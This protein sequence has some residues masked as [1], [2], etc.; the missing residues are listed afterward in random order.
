MLRF[1]QNQEVTPPRDAATAV[2]VRETDAGLEVYCIKRSERSAFMGGAVVFPGGKVDPSDLDDAWPACTAGLAPRSEV[3]AEGPVARALAIAACRETFE[4]AGLLCA[5]DAAGAPAGA[6]S[7]S[8]VSEAIRNGA[9]LR[10]AVRMAGL[11]LALVDLVPF[12]RWVTP[13]AE[14]RRFDARFYVVRA[15][16]GQV[17]ACDGHEA[18]HG[19]W[20]CPA[21]VLDRSDRGE[22]WLAPPTLR[23]LELLAEVSTWSGALEVA[24]QQSLLP[25]C[26]E[27]RQSLS[28]DVMLTLPGDPE[29]STAEV[30]VTG[31]TRFIFKDGR[32]RSVTPKDI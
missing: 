17:A 7:L 28:G 5:R 11:E 31:T 12:A 24:S 25:V 2:V 15:P 8:L 23:T 26:P 27:V 1:D 30:R 4:E 10:D 20:A 9:S 16:E 14:S 13:T 3:L 19:F 29:H 6:A 18:T 32:F 21:D 22:L